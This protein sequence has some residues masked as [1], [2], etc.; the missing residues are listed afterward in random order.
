[1]AN[2]VLYN[3]INYDILDAIT[4]IGRDYLIL[5][6][7]NDLKNIFFLES[8]L[9]NDTRKYSLPPKSFKVEDNQNCD[10]KR[11]EINVLVNSAVEILKQEVAHGILNNQEEIQKRFNQIKSFIYTDLTIQSLIEDQKNLNSSSFSQ[12]SDYLQ[13][14]LEHQFPLSINNIAEE[15]YSYLDKP[16][17]SND[18]LN[19]EWLYKLDSKQLRELASD[20]N[21][22]SEELIYILDALEKRTETEKA[23]EHY[24]EAGRAMTLTKKDNKAAFIDILLLSLITGSFLLLLLISI[25]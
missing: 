9:V 20:K 12:I 8:S 5:S 6:D 1:M 16:I 15:Q 22:T 10:L 19:Y 25:F 23:I 2:K 21:R 24:T 4:L 17:R 3:N 7:N 14:D 18:G 13:K 11:L